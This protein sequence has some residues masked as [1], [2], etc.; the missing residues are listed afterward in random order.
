VEALLQ[1]DPLLSERFRKLPATPGARYFL[2]KKLRD[3]AHSRAIRAGKVAAERL[4]QAIQQT[5]V[6]VRTLSLRGDEPGGPPLLLK[7]ALLIPRG[8]LL[9]IVGTA[10]RAA[11]AS[12]PLVVEPS[13]PWPPYHFCPSLGDPT[14]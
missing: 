14:Q 12:V 10:E 5:G 6:G 13:G 8:K 2:E 11:A 3:E 1:T 4:H 9:D 7:L